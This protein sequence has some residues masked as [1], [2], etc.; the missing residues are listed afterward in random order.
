MDFLRSPLGGPF[1]QTFARR[2]SAVVLGAP[3]SEL[4]VIVDATDSLTALGVSSL[5]EDQFGKV[6]KDIPILLR[7]FVAAVQGIEIFKDA[8]GVHWTDVGFKEDA[9]GT[10]RKVADVEIVLDCLRAGIK[11][12]LVG[13]GDYL[14]DL[15]MGR[16]E[17][18]IAREV[19]GL[20]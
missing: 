1:R 2:F 17:L 18:S 10:G 6:C 13:F 20:T 14:V 8:M 7:N 11:D 3:V 5:K 9:E 16:G 12:L 4:N 15:G 19:A